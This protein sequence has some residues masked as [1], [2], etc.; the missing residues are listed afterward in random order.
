MRVG[1]SYD[2]KRGIIHCAKRKGT[3][4][5]A[6]T[7]RDGGCGS[8]IEFRLKQVA[9][10]G[11]N[12]F[13]GRQ[14]K[15]GA[16]YLGGCLDEA[17]ITSVYAI[18]PVEKLRETDDF[19]HVNGKENQNNNENGV[20]VVS[21]SPSTKN[22]GLLHKSS[23]KLGFAKKKANTSEANGHLPNGHK[24]ID[25]PFRFSGDGV[26][27]KAKLIGVRDV[28]DARGDQMCQ[29][30][31]Q[32]CKA[33]VK[34]SGQHKQRILFN[35]SLEGLRIKEQS[36]GQTLYSFPVSKVSFIAKDVTDNRAFGFIYG[37][38]EEKHK[39]YA[40]KTEKTSDQVVISIRDMF[41]VV[42]EMKKKQMEEAKHS[43]DTTSEQIVNGVGTKNDVHTANVTKDENGVAVAD[44]LDL[45]TELQNLKQG[46]KDMNTAWADFN[47]RED[48][49]QVLSNSLSSASFGNSFNHH[50]QAQFYQG[51]GVVSSSTPDFCS[52]SGGTSSSLNETMSSVNGGDPFGTDAFNP[53]S[54]ASTSFL[55]N[56]QNSPPIGGLAAT[57]PP[58]PPSASRRR[59]TSSTSSNPTATALFDGQHSQPPPVLLIDKQI[60]S[61][62]TYSGAGELHSLGSFE[63]PLAGSDPFD[64]SHATRLV[65]N[66]GNTH[67]HHGHAASTPIPRLSS[68]SSS[69]FGGGSI[70]LEM[71]QAPSAIM[72][73]RSSVL[74][75]F[76]SPNS[77]SVFG[78]PANQD[79]FTSP[80]N[81]F[82]QQSVSNSAFNQAFYGSQFAASQELSE[83]HSPFET[84]FSAPNITDTPVSTNR[85]SRT[86]NLNPIPSS[87]N[88]TSLT[89]QLLGSNTP[90]MSSSPQQTLLNANILKAPNATS[91]DQAFNVLCNLDKL[92]S[93]QPAPPAA[94]SIGV[95]SM[96]KEDPFAQMRP[97]PK[98][99]INQL[100]GSPPTSSPPSATTNAIPLSTLDELYSS[101]PSSIKNQSIS[102]SFGFGGAVFT[103]SSA[104]PVPPRSSCS[105]ASAAALL[106]P[107]TPTENGPRRRPL[108]QPIPG[109]NGI[110]VGGGFFDHKSHD[111]FADD[112]FFAS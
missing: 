54:A 107:P 22:Q 80:V 46:V 58:P 111:P 11:R 40:I 91:I 62:T 104:P 75:D 51:T 92:I 38:P 37:S 89:A 50:Q 68:T 74:S 7:T 81:G 18:M 42:Y 57:V 61:S 36:N 6:I 99:S 96:P 85:L 93:P 3:C 34:S 108:P 56:Q 24:R 48:E 71:S 101:S 90:Q 98:K 60:S 25:D 43:K 52:L 8:S 45:E 29:D 53:V 77:N 13:C 94:Q 1:S 4:A 105:L 84:A 83:N 10:L 82:E 17:I 30:A 26:D 64:T 59:T 109:A 73:T 31:M 76:S 55:N 14:Y 87:P 5:I 28:S 86:P 95:G 33:I 2:E 110:S 9:W 69:H 15:Q 12:R 19:N 65:N 41:H 35:I 72:A 39:F 103:S 32:L 78:T 102:P 47:P 21:T 20:N 23:S 97:P 70:S 63:S 112:P 66:V 67:G 27:F 44:L 100:R 16:H 106:P 79:V 88:G 49:A